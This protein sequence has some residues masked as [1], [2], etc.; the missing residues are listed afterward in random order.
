VYINATIEGDALRYDDMLLGACCYGI[1][2][3]IGQLALQ[4]YLTQLLWVLFVKAYEHVQY[5]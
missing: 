3:V 1:S 2:C 4:V 5:Y